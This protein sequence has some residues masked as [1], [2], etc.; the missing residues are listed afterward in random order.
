MHGLC[1]S[2]EDERAVNPFQIGHGPALRAKRDRGGEAQAHCPSVH[3]RIQ[4]GITHLLTII[5]PLPMWVAARSD[6]ELSHESQ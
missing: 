5:M 3:V 4:P 1:S 6:Y 2:V